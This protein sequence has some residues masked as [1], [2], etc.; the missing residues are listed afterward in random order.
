MTAAERLFAEAS[1]LPD[2]GRGLPFPPTSA[3][4]R[5]P[6]HRPYFLWWLDCTVAEL[7][8]HLA[9]GD[10]EKQAYYLGALLREANTRDVWLFT[11]PAKVRAAWPSVVR[12]LG[13]T[14]ARWAWL[15][16]IHESV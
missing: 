10:A 2:E 6:N 14:R 7:R 13:P 15:L 16:G 9:E 12:Y 1:V 5:D 8:R 4:L 3:D 11:T